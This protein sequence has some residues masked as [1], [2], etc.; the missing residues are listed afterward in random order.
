MRLIWSHNVCNNRQLYGVSIMR[1]E[2]NGRDTEFIDLAHV[3]GVEKMAT[4]TG[5]SSSSNM[6][7]IPAAYIEL[8]VRVYLTVRNRV[9]F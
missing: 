7:H 2:K 5:S 3:E 6:S 1:G 4:S 9:L 8:V